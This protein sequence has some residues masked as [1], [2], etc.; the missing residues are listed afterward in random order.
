MIEVEVI[1]APKPI[2]TDV[3][4]QIRQLDLGQRPVARLL[5]LALRVAVGKGP[6]RHRE[7][8]AVLKNWGVTPPLSAEGVPRFAVGHLAD[9]ATKDLILAAPAAA[10][11]LGKGVLK[12]GMLCAVL[13][14]AVEALTTRMRAEQAGAHAR[15]FTTGHIVAALDVIAALSAPD[16]NGH[17]WIGKRGPSDKLVADFELLRGHTPAPGYEGVFAKAVEIAECSRRRTT[18]PWQRG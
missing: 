2:P 3:V 13:N 11:L 6:E 12:S 7:W 1:E 10:R 14:T 18:L 17:R 9:E 4:D 5:C 8:I 16:E 15:G